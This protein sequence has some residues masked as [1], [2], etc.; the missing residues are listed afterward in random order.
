MASNKSTS[1]SLLG[2]RCLI[3]L[4][5][6]YKKNHYQYLLRRLEVLEI[7]AIQ[8]VS[9]QSEVDFAIIG[10]SNSETELERGIERVLQHGIPTLILAGYG[11]NHADIVIK[12]ISSIDVIEFEIKDC[13]ASDVLRIGESFLMQ[14][15]LEKS[16]YDIN[17]EKTIECSSRL[18]LAISNTKPYYPII[19]DVSVSMQ[20]PLLV[21]TARVEQIHGK[22]VF[23]EQLLL[24]EHMIK[25]LLYK[26]IG[27][28]KHS[29]ELEL[30]LHE[31]L[32]RNS[33]LLFAF[34]VSGKSSLRISEMKAI[35]VKID[36]GFPWISTSQGFSPTPG[37]EIIDGLARVTSDS[38]L[39][40]LR[41]MHES[42][43]KWLKETNGDSGNER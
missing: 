14:L 40:N 23:D 16:V 26:N 20:T 29:P 6:S 31:D 4:D 9:S 12:P 17:S 36:D 21:C 41:I 35:L 39:R 10:F 27:T 42:L 13:A 22:S 15:E 33:P 28:K 24:L 1:D 7:D 34:L 43:P 37:V 2:S 25:Y 32:V 5:S 38:L 8:D 30:Y 11:Q 19:V 18:P 3:I